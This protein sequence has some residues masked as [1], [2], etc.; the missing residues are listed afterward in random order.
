MAETKS[1]LDQHTAGPIAI[2]FDYQ[3]YYFMFL[4]LELSNGQKIGFEVKDDVHIDKADGTTIL[5]QAKHTVDKSQ[6][7]TTLD[8]DLWKTLSNW[9]AFIKADKTNTD[10]LNKYSFVLVTNKNENNNK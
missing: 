2:G 4:A 9:S 5:Y 3:F 7:L 6:N 1:I 10:F 8:T